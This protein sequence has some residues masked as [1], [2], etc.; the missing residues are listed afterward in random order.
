MI[1]GEDIGEK[2]T[3]QQ[4]IKL[5]YIVADPDL[6]PPTGMNP[7]T[8][9]D[10]ADDMRRGDKFPPLTVFYDGKTYLLADGFHRYRAALAIKSKTISCDVRRGSKR[11]ALLFSVSS[12]AAHGRRRSKADRRMAV[13]KLLEDKEWGKWSD[14]EISRRCHVG[15]PFVGQ[16]RNELAVTGSSS[17]ERT[18]TTKHGTKA[19]MKTKNI[20]RKPKPAKPKMTPQM[21]WDLDHHW[22][23]AA[24]D[25]INEQIASL[26]KEHPQA[27]HAVTDFPSDQHTLTSWRL[28]DMA[29][30]LTNFAAAWRRQR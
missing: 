14:R 18:Y 24:L 13:T 1:N 4:K 28:D 3:K 12:N 22:I 9:E 26:Q 11:D 15:H 8:I 10:Y 23:S 20:G 25:E 5:S 29:K 21:K 17:S 6:Q 2:M 19:K 16:L 27:S 30:W 7:E